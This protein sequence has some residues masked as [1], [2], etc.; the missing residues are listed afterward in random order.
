MCFLASIALTTIALA[1]HVI[2]RQPD[3]AAVDSL[4]RKT[5]LL[6]KV[7]RDHAV[8]LLQHRR[9]QLRLR[10]S[11]AVSSHALRL[12]RPVIPQPPFAHFCGDIFGGFGAYATGRFGATSS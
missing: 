10:G 4:G 9:C 7:A 2:H 1:D 11:R 12:N 8:H 5:R 3:R 6:E